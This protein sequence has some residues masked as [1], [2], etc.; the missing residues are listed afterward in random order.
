MHILHNKQ[1]FK[2]RVRY[3]PDVASRP[4][5]LRK[6]LERART[7]LVRLEAECYALRKLR[8]ISR[9][10]VTALPEGPLQE[11]MLTLANGDVDGDD[12]EPSRSS[13]SAI[14]Q[15]IE[16]VLAEI[17]QDGLDEDDLEIRKVRLMSSLCA[18]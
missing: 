1:P 16:R 3:A 2:N 8:I 6:D 4:D 15:R 18:T 14:E 9:D 5:I 7:L 10:E 13:L 11:D 12:P 17:P